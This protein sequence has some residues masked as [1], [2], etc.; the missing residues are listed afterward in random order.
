[1]IEITIEDVNNH[2]QLALPFIQGQLTKDPQLI[3]LFGEHVGLP[4]NAKLSFEAFINENDHV[5]FRKVLITQSVGIDQTR[6]LW[7]KE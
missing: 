7:P 1:M 5:E 3:M 6:T 2:L 4:Q